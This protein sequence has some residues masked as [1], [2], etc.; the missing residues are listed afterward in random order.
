MS[1]FKI[2]E[3]ALPILDIEDEKELYD[4]INDRLPNWVVD[5]IDNYSE[6]YPRF[7][8]NWIMMCK[9]LPNSPNP[10]KIILVSEIPLD[11]PLQREKKRFEDIHTASS[12]LTQKGYVVRRNGELVKCKACK[13]GVASEK[14][15]DFM[16]TIGDKD[17]PSSWDNTCNS[18][19]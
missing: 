10:K 12:V 14:V 9:N 11:K 7:T 17:I 16:K 18:C 5:F 3:W 13:R 19:K 6:D 1:N 2:P 8:E 4:F 15:Y